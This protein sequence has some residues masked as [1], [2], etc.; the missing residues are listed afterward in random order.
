MID[1]ILKLL[2]EAEYLGM[3]ENI[4]IAKGKYKLPE[5]IKEAKEQNKRARAWQK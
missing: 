3:G 4:D 1:H 2:K 5:S